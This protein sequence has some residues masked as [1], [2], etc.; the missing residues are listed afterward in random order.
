LATGQA[1]REEL[2]HWGIIKLLGQGTATGTTARIRD[3]TRLDS[4]AFPSTEFDGAWVRLSAGAGDGEISRVD[5]LD[6]ALGD[7]YVDPVFTAAPTSATTYE[8]YRA[9]VHPD[10]VDR[11]R[12]QALIRIC[13]Q[14]ALHPLSEVSN[15]AYE[16]GVTNW[17][18]TSSTRVAGAMAF[19]NEFSR[20]SLVVT[21]TGANGRVSSASIYCRPDMSFYLHV[22]VSVRSGTA[23]IV[24]RDITNG[25]DI[26]LSGTATTATLR[27]FTAFEVTGIIPANSA[28]IQVW[29]RGQEATAVV[30]WG[31][32]NFHWRNQRMIE[33]DPRVTSTKRV[34]DIFMVTEPIAIGRSQTW[35]EE[36]R[37]RISGV[38]TR[39]VGDAVMLH[40]DEPLSDYPYFYEER[41]FYTALSSAYLTTANRTTGDAAS[42]TCDLYYAAAGMVKILAETYLIKQPEDQVFWRSVLDRADRELSRY[43]RE[44]GPDPKPRIERKSSYYIPVLKV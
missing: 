22:P 40:L 33:L 42:T 18:A 31:P 41:I 14:W 1:I 34:G 11:A 20:N 27:G 44:F 25:A 29:L 7:L 19:P 6:Q 9:G 8:V 39:Q 4:I 28:E 12:D 30:E 36:D 10:D 24:V 35:G 3:A 21:N 13:S 37:E 17:T 32:V 15:A 26:S 38:D 16:D 2:Q 43:E 23:E 5:Y